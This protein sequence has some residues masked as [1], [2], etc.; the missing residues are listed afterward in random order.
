MEHLKEGGGAQA[1]KVWERLYYSDEVLTSLSPHGA[2]AIIKTTI[3]VVAAITTTTTITTTILQL[4]LPLIV[5]I[6]TT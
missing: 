3:A 2:T 6:T 4:P 5:I 1:I